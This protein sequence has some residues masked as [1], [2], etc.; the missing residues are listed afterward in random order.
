MLAVLCGLPIEK[1][2]LDVFQLVWTV[3]QVVIRVQ[4]CNVGWWH[5]LQELWYTFERSFEAPVG[6]V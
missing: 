2:I 1:M 5:I 4:T 6:K 3:T